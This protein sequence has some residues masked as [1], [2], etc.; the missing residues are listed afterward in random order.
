MNQASKPD[1]SEYALEEQEWLESL[2]YVLAT[3]PPEKVQ[4]L[5]R[6]LLDRAEQTGVQFPF[7]ANRPYVNTIRRAEQPA[8]PGD[9]EIERR[10]KSL[11]R[12]NAM[13]MVVRSV[14]GLCFAPRFDR[15][16]RDDAGFL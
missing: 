15:Q 2:D 3:Y 7:S 16:V 6:Q 4:L 14:A 12:W 11:I 9:R 5:L 8:F 1:S 13:A 10:I